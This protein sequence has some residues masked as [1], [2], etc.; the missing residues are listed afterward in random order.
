MGLRISWITG[1]RVEGDLASSTELGISRAMERNG[2]KIHMISPG[3]WRFW[4]FPSFWIKTIQSQG[5][6]NFFCRKGLS[7]YFKK[8]E[9]I[10]RMERTFHN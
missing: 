7:A 4:D 9:R 3:K 8:R 1:R 6:A 10:I 5:I 2:C